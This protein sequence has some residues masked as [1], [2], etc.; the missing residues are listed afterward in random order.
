MLLILFKVDLSGDYDTLKNVLDNAIGETG[1]LY[2]FI[3]CAGMALCGTLE[4][5]SPSDIMVL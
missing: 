5:S 4:D 2:L 1:P 3:N